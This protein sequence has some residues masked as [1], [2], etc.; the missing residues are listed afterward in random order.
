MK[1]NLDITSHERHIQEISKY[2]PIP[3]SPQFLCFR[4]QIW[5]S[6]GKFQLRSLDQVLL[7]LKMIKTFHW[8][9]RREENV[10]FN[11]EVKTSS[12]S[13]RGGQPPA[14]WDEEGHYSL[15]MI[16]IIII[17]SAVTDQSL[18]GDQHHS[19]LAQLL[20]F[21]GDSSSDIK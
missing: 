15:S 14:V 17:R 13:W 6:F 11:S 19:L 12:A 21:S 7:K 18:W 4:I 20:Q 2:S 16:S 5:K 9:R 10:L 1:F 3:Q 8:L